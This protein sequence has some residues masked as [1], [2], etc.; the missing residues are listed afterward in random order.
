MDL[1]QIEYILKIAEEKNISR[2]AEK[3]FISQPALNQ[4]LINLEKELGTPLFDRQ[5]GELRL[6]E[7]GRVYVE[8]GR[9][10]LDIKKDA[11]ARIEDVADVKNAQLRVGVTPQSGARILG[12]V[13]KRFYAA[14]PEVRTI[15]EQ[16]DTVSLQKAVASGALDLAIGTIGAEKD[17]S[18][19][20]YEVLRTMEMLLVMSKEDPYLAEAYVDEKGQRCIDLRKLKDE[21][22][23]LGPIA[24]TSHLMT[25][26][27]FEEAGFLPRLYHQGGA[28]PL[29]LSMVEMNQCCTFSE[30]HHSEALPDTVERLHLSTH[31]KLESVVIYKK[32]RHLTM[33][34]RDFINI[35]RLFWENN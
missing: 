5:R 30:E 32:S 11:Y 4:Q 17:E 16:M 34:E 26:M 14:H 25:D 27:L 9:Q 12:W 19:L 23:A 33:A 29:R 10:I 22:F 3:L 31:P 13:Y 20:C 28:F 24:G 2:A 7:A 35:A 15:I 18:R 6:T 8:A 1:R 21:S